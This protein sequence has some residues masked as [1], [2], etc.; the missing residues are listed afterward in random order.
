MFIV[1]CLELMKSAHEPA[2]S[3]VGRLKSAEGSAS[4]G[5]PGMGRVLGTSYLSSVSQSQCSHLNN[6]LGNTLKFVVCT[7]DNLC[8]CVLCCV[9]CCIWLKS[10]LPPSRNDVTPSICS[11]TLAVV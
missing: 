4:Q 2:G 1:S 10:R 8:V 6:G 11:L 9:S 7:L 3:S 5:C